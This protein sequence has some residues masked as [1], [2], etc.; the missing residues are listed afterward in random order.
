MLFNR[1]SGRGQPHAVQVR[2]VPHDEH[3]PCVQIAP[4]DVVL[5]IGFVRRDHDIGN[6]QVDLLQQEERAV[7]HSFPFS[8][9]SIADR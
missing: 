6:L 1:S 4:P 3:L 9:D 7:D 8:L 2:T 5:T